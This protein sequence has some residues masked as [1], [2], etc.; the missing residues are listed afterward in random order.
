M[1]TFTLNTN[2]IKLGVWCLCH[3][4]CH[5]EE[6]IRIRSSKLYGHEYSLELLL[7]MGSIGV[8][9]RGTV[10]YLLSWPPLIARC[11]DADADATFAMEQRI[12]TRACKPWT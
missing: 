2:P 5:L 3:S 6:S 1:C 7:V 8:D 11:A 4:E 10:P 9:W 12:I